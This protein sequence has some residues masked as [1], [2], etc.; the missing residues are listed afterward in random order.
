MKNSFSLKYET[1]SGECDAIACALNVKVQG[2]L[3]STTVEALQRDFTTMLASDNVRLAD[4]SVMELDLKEAALIDSQGLNLLVSVSR[5]MKL[6]KVPM[7]VR[8]SL[9]SV[10]LTLLSVGLDRQIEVLF[11]DSAR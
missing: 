6:R 4:L 3:K 7:R 5:Q 10:Y 2:D 1:I 8:V 9:R 11:E